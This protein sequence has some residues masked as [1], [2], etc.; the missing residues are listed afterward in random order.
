MWAFITFCPSSET[1]TCVLIAGSV[2][3]CR[4]NSSHTE[5]MQ[6]TLKISRILTRSDF[7]P[8][9]FSLSFSARKSREIAFWFL[10]FMIC[11][12]IS[13]AALVPDGKHRQRGT[14][15]VHGRRNLHR[16]LADC[17]AHGVVQTVQPLP[18]QSS[19]EG[20]TDIG[21]GQPKFDV[22]HL[23]YHRLLGGISVNNRSI[24]TPEGN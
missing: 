20:G 22:V 9:I 21:T 13:A 3:E 11:I 17:L 6:R 19:V 10:R 4:V 5:T 24:K 2:W 14:Q 12:W 1:A 7:Q 23:I 15:S 18:V 16:Q 8:A